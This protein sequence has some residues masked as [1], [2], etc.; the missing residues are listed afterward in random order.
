MTMVY[1]RLKKL[2]DA[3][4]LRHEY[5]LHGRPGVYLATKKCADLVEVGVPPAKV[6]LKSFDHDLAVVDLALV[7]DAQ[8]QWITER[9]IRSKAVS[10]V[11]GDGGRI[12]RSGRL[13][14]V[15]DGLI[16]SPWGDVW[17]VELEISG[18]DNARYLDIFRGYVGRHRERIPEEEDPDE[19][20]YE[21]LE[22][23]IN[24]G[25][26][27]DGVAWYFWSDSKCER[28]LEASAEAEAEDPSRSRY[29]HFFFGDAAAPRWPP[30]DKMDEQKERDR[31]EDLKRRRAS[32]EEAK[33]AHLAGVRLTPEEADYILQ[34]AHQHK[35][36]GRLFK[37]QLT[38]EERQHAL[39]EG[40]KA[41]LGHERAN[42]PQFR[43]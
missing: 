7:L 18:K 4:L 26:E 23:Y 38:E 43:G 14:R 16:V 42:Y 13:G 11:R 5:V 12:S 22:E 35:N 39:Q 1:R 33:K 40:L 3:D 41:K 28:V 34:E 36:E 20:P 10:A 15:P 17:A 24:S 37:R 29:C 30:F 9:E 25:G 31:L 2:V 8:P 19:W 27:V 6:D 32:Y 21:Q